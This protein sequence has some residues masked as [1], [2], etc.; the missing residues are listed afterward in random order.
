MMRGEVWSFVAAGN[1]VNLFG[2]RKKGITITN[3]F[4]F[5]SITL[6]YSLFIETADFYF[7]NNYDILNPL[8]FRIT[9]P[10]DHENSKIN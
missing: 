5:P 10:K 3:H 7:L 8:S 9:P 4:T 1:L 2:A 6:C